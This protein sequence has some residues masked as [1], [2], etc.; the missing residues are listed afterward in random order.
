MVRSAVTVQ[1]GRACVL[2]GAGLGDGDGAVAESGRR[3]GADRDVVRRAAGRQ[4]ADLG[5]ERTGA[6]RRGHCIVV[7][8]D[9]RTVAIILEDGQRSL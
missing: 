8:G 3:E 6:D 5:L 7:A 2:A 4:E 9:E 1:V